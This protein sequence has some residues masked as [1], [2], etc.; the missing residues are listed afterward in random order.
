MTLVPIQHRE[1]FG[2]LLISNSNF[3]PES[4]KGWEIQRVDRDSSI[5][6]L[7]NT[8]PLYVVKRKNHYYYYYYYYY[9]Y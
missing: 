8:P 6:W 3:G 1:E 9:Y 7:D 4:Q 2:Q 5:N